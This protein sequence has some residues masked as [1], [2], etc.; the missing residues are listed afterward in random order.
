MTCP[1]CRQQVTVLLTCFTADEQSN[2]GANADRQSIVDGV[3]DFNHR[4]S[5]A[6]RTVSP[7]QRTLISRSFPCSVSR[8]FPR[9][10]CSDPTHLS[11]NLQYRRF[12]LDATHSYLPDRHRYDSVRHLSIGYSPRRSRRFCRF[13]R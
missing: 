13:T 6:P 8:I 12:K 7:F 9:Y 5:G 3:R 1:V 11:S 2:R 10:S 4:F